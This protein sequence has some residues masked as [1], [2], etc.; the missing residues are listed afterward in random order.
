MTATG[1]LSGLVDDIYGQANRARWSGRIVLVLVIVLGGL[2][3][4]LFL[5]RQIPFPFI[6]GGSPL[7]DPNSVLGGD[8]LPTIIGRLI[9]RIGAVVVGIF[10]IQV[11]LGFVRYYFRLAEHLSMIANLL[12]LTEGKVENIAALGAVLLPSLIDFGRM[13]RSPFEY[14][15]RGVVDTLKE[16]VAKL[17]TR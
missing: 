1:L 7:G 8:L 3:I 9:E 2:L 13:P 16:T 10:I 17:P 6:L 15:L 12:R 4:S 14:A 11:M 5:G